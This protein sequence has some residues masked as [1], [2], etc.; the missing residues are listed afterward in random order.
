MPI[1][2][3]KVNDFISQYMNS[4][5][6][7]TLLDVREKQE[8]AEARISGSLHIPM[9]QVPGECDNL[10]QDLPLIVMC[11]SGQRSLMV[12]DVLSSMGFENLLNLDGGILAWIK[13]GQAI[14]SDED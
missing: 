8:Y 4:N 13:A 7:Y 11:R 3:L 14:E 12:A 2:N 10:P 9:H 1:T 6:P 5:Q